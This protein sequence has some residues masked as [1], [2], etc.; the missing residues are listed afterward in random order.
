MATGNIINNTLGVGV[1]TSLAFT[2]TTN[3]VVGTPTNDNASAG[4]V[5]EMISSVI[6]F[7]SSTAITRNTAQNVTSISLTAGDWDVWGNVNLTNG[8]TAVTQWLG[9]TSATSATLPDSSLYNNVSVITATLATST[10][11]STPYARYSLTATT[12]I[13]LSCYLVNSS[14][15]GSASGGI[16]ARRAR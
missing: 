16:F 9:W 7:A 10:G 12:T 15:D 5:G 13:Y 1:A 6:P 11:V 4:Y 8:G 14:G 2:P 3:G